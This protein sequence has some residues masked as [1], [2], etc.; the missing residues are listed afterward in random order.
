[1]EPVTGVGV[2]TEPTPED[3]ALVELQNRFTPDKQIAFLE[4]SA[5]RV[6][7]QTAL[8]GTVVAAGGLVAL[9]TILAN[10]LSFGLMLV[11]VALSGLAILLALTTQVVTPTRLRI[12]N[13]VEIKAWFE[14]YSGWRGIFLTAA[15]WLIVL[16][17]IS[18]AAAVGFALWGQ[19]DKPTFDVT[20][21]V[22]P[23][24]EASAEAEAVPDTYLVKAGLTVQAEGVDDVLTLTVSSDGETRGSS[25][26]HST[27]V[28]A[29]AVE[30]EAAGLPAADD[31]T[32][33]GESNSWTCTTTISEA[34]VTESTCD[35]KG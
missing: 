13:L 31:V 5:A 6:V 7:S 2:G 4:A 33:V 29:I 35:R 19:S 27:G 11:A 21:S 20:V 16:S 18:A 3:L 17:F 10:P 32:V 28:A 25:Q 9:S 34:D 30:L 8:V 23:G 12:G 26:K 14:R 22:S 1:V 24:K 15:T